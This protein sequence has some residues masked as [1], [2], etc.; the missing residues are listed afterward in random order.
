MKSIKKEGSGLG[1]QPTFTLLIW[2]K[3]IGKCGKNR[4]PMPIE[5]SKYFL[6]FVLSTKKSPAKSNTTTVKA[7]K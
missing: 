3:V 1:N 7:A 5:E 2:I 4:T 6:I